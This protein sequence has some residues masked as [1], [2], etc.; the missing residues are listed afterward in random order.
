MN[1]QEERFARD[2]LKRG[3]AKS[4]VH[5]VLIFRHMYSHLDLYKPIDKIVDDLEP[6]QLDWAMQ[7]VRSTLKEDKKDTV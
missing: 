7:Q 5:S 4:N 3:L 1:K 2:T 6:N